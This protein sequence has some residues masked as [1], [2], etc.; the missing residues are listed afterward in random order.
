[1][2]FTNRINFYKP[3]LCSQDTAN[4]NTPTEALPGHTELDSNGSIPDAVVI[5]MNLAIKSMQ[6]G[7][8]GGVK[9]K[10]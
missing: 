8:G 2:R 7:G 3:I 6:N 1:M 10:H 4:L 9:A 5:D